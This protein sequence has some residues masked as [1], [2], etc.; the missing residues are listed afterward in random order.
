MVAQEPT[1]PAALQPR[2]RISSPRPGGSAIV[3][4]VLGLTGDSLIVR[5]EGR[6][7]PL[8]LP[9]ETVGRIELSEGRHARTGRGA[10][11]GLV[12]G[13]VLGTGLVV[14]A[15]SNEEPG[16]F[17]GL[18]TF[19]ALVTGVG[20][21]AAGVGIGALVGSFVHTERWREV[22]LHEL[23]VGAG[24]Q[25]GVAISVRLGLRR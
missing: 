12:S 21:S 13:A 4:N 9:L 24:A 10:L 16:D 22:P 18:L 5:Q 7:S 23:R 20:V 19:L 25:G 15:A 11:I 2:V 6:A 1:L 17:E 3:G 14:A 8:L